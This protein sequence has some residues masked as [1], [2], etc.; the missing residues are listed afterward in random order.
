EPGSAGRRGDA[1]GRPHQRPVPPPGVPGRRAGTPGTAAAGTHRRDGVRGREPGRRPAVADRRTG[2]AGTARAGL[3]RPRYRL[4]RWYFSF[5]SPYSWIAYR[6]LT[7]RYP[8]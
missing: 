5:R 6:D 4:M 1:A 2:V 7:T 3:R 8:D